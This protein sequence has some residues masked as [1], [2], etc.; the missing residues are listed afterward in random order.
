MSKIVVVTDSTCNLPPRFV[1][2]YEIPIIPLN[3][4][5]G[6]ETYLDGVTLTQETF[7]TWLQERE[8]FPTT[9]QPSAGRFIEFFRS[10]Q[11]ERAPDTI[12]CLTISSDL[13]GT[14]S[15]A[16]QAKEALPELQLEVVDSRSVSAGLGFQVLAATRA[17]RE[18]AEIDDVLARVHYVRAKTSL[19]FTVGTLEYLHRGGRIGGASRLLGTALNLKP[20]LTVENGRVEALEKVRGRRKSLQR[21]LEIAE[22]RLAG[23]APEMAAIIDVDAEEEAEFLAQE[24][25]ARLKPRESFR[26]VVA[27]VVGGH[28]GPGTVGLGFYV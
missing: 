14:Y 7:Y 12:L 10:V 17:A 21:L 5:W 4:Q 24:V 18:G 1:S 15:S 3:V 9:S 27:P 11:E 26:A 13:S 6:E 23:R 22:E 28:A 25:E 2:E 16:M 19:V 8:G 20:L